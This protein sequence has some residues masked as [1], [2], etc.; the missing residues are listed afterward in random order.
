MSLLLLYI[1]LAVCAS[2]LCSILEAVLLSVSPSFIATLEEDRPAVG[3]RMRKLKSDVDQPLAA[4]LSLNTIANTIGAAG[5]GAQAQRLW[6]SNALAI[7]SAALTLLILVVAEI[8][9]KTLGAVYWRSLV[10]F[11]SRALPVLIVVLAP[12]VWL[13][14]R[15]TTGL[16]RRGAQAGGQ[17]LSR[18]ELAALATVGREH[19]LIDESESRI[20]R[21]L[22]LLS[23]LRARDIMTPRTVV[24][25]LST[26]TTVGE[27]IEDRSALSFSRIPVW[28]GEREHVVGYVLKDRLLLLGARGERGREVGTLV[29]PLV[30]VPES[31][32]VTQVFERLLQRREHMALVIDEYGGVDGVVTMEDVLETLLGLEIVDEADAVKDMRAMAR[33]KWEERARR[34]RAQ[35]LDDESD[36]PGTD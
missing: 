28:K 11:A 5:V 14:R 26:D 6:G 30:V 16:R 7:A 23:E 1:G 8:V 24:Y 34:M 25:M 35:S 2:F 15:I 21:N 17:T 36:A 22:F 4:V 10:G 20:L 3:R 12:L 19:G 18:E 9:P 33:A 29:R 27:A 32:A 13:S 31:L